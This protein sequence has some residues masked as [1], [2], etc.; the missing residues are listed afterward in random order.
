MPYNHPPSEV[1]PWAV[2]GA[3]Y[4]L[5]KFKYIH[6]VYLGERN[7]PESVDRPNG[8]DFND[9]YNMKWRR[10]LR[11]YI[12]LVS[13][14]IGIIRDA[15]RAVGQVGLADDLWHADARWLDW[16]ADRGWPE[17]QQKRYESQRAASETQ[18]GGKHVDR[19]NQQLKDGGSL[20]DTAMTSASTQPTMPL[21]EDDPYPEDEDEF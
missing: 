18:E 1:V 11:T 4:P 8:I 9:Q 15:L 17:E 10:T 14:N 21:P 3:P 2:Y 5:R 13:K 19:L 12:V 20:W 6:G 7:M 16:G